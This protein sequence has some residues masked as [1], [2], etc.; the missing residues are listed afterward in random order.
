[1]SKAKEVAKKEESGLAISQERP[2]FMNSDSVRGQEN[3]TL[4]D[5][6]IPRLGLIQSLSPQRKKSDP[7]YIEGAE[8]GLLFNTVTSELYG[9]SVLFVPVLFRKEFLIWKDQN[10]GGGFLGAF[11]TEEEAKQEFANKDYEGKVTDKGDPMYEIVDTAQQFGLI[12]DPK[13]KK[14]PEEIVLSMSKSGMKASRQ[15]NSMAKMA[16]GDRFSRVY[17]VK[18]I[19][20]ANSAGQEYYAHNIRSVGFVD[21]PTFR[22]AEK[23]Y[24]S[25]KSGAKNAAYDQG[26]AST[27][28]TEEEQDY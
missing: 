5:V 9:A 23:M 2:E 6:T 27:S 13:G 8:E 16:G 15:L 18:G 11:D 14:R 10:S 20:T 19:E 3:V 1:M 24:D 25:V 26:A 22:A 7:S 12:I 4:D 21:E 28:E 17:E